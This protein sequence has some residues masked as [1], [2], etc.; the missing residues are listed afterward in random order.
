MIYKSIISEVIK[1]LLIIF[2][3]I[4]ILVINIII[5]IIVIV[6]IGTFIF[7]YRIKR[8]FF[9]FIYNITRYII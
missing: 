6:S 3:K 1:S 5:N 2:G 8:I 9:F 4:I 7:S